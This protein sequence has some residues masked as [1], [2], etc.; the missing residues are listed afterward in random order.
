MI[1]VFVNDHKQEKSK[2]IIGEL[3]D[4]EGNIQFSCIRQG[5]IVKIVQNESLKEMVSL[6]EKITELE[7]TLWRQRHGR[8]YQAVLEAVERPLLESVLERAEGN[9]L[10]AA[11][12]LGLNR[13]TIRAKIKKL[14]I[15]P[16]RWRPL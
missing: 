15:N 10:K 5:S 3:L 16:Q 11:R 8:L 9:Q 1:T 13:N 4:K 12:I 6:A 2:E 14:G 7:N